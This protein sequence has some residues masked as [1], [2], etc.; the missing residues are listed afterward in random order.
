M[1]IVRAD[2]FFSLY[3]RAIIGSGVVGRGEIHLPLRPHRAGMRMD[4]APLQ[5]PPHTKGYS[6]SAAV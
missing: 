1:A 4:G 5:P 6:E 3:S 2:A